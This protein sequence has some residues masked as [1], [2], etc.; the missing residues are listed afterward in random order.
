MAPPKNRDPLPLWHSV[1]FRNEFNCSYYNMKMIRRGVLTWG[2]FQSL[3]DVRLLN[4]LPRTWKGVY[5]HGERLLN[6]IS[7]KGGFDTPTVHTQNW[8]GA[9]LL[10]F[11]ASQPGVR[12]PQTPEVWGQWANAQLPPRVKDFAQ[13]VL[14]HK[15]TVHERV[16]KRSGTDKCPI[17]SQKESIKHAVVECSMF[18]AAAAV[19]QHYYGPSGN[20]GREVPSPGY[21]GVRPTGVVAEHGP[22]AGQCGRQEVPTGDTDVKLRQERRQCS[23]HI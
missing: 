3:E 22:K 6:K 7:S 4:A 17:C 8:T 16:Y 19:I 2:H 5:N 9:W 13:R 20:R 18:K 15:L 21:D 10:Q 1:Y 11:Y 14:W 12:D 23:R